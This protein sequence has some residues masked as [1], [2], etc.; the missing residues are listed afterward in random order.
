MSA[1]GMP[2]IVSVSA[3]PFYRRRLRAAG[4]SASLADARENR[5]ERRRERAEFAEDFLAFLSAVSRGSRVFAGLVFRRDSLQ[6]LRS[7]NAL[8]NSAGGGVPSASK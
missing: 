7:A 3:D 8:S 6:P 4:A 2:V 1:F 5:A